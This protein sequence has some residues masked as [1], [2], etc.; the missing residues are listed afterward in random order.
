MV[1]YLAKF[2]PDLSTVTELLRRLLNKD[3]TPE[4]AFQEVEYLITGQPVME[5]LT[6][7][8]NA[9]IQSDASEFWTSW[10]NNARMATYS[11]HKK[12]SK[13]N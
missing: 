12:S 9:A 13:Y 4:K 2:L 5:V 1:N 3:D 6:I 7:K 8:K 11:I 10:S